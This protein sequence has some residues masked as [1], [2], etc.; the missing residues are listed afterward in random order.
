MTQNNDLATAGA[1][2]PNRLGTSA[3]PTWGSRLIRGLFLSAALL[4]C[5]G[6][7]ALGMVQPAPA[8][9][10]PPE[11]SLVQNV[12]PFPLAADPI[13]AEYSAT[14]PNTPYVTETRIRSGDTIATILKR[15]DIGNTNLSSYLAKE[16]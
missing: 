3:Q 14:A 8:E 11:Q 9:P 10:I 16:P 4:F 15:L 13:P 1:I 6:A 12:L 7:A 2:A 5:I